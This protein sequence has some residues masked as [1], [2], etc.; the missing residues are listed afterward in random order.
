[1][2]SP[3]EFWADKAAYEETARKLA[4]MFQKNFT[5]TRT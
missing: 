2:L 3:R 4:G 1:V 5:S